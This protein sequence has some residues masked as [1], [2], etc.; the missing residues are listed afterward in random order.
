[1]PPPSTTKPPPSY[2]EAERHLAR[3]DRR[4]RKLIRRI[5]KCTLTPHDDYFSVLVHTIVSQQISSKAAL[6]I[7][8]R[9]AVAARSKKFRPSRL[10]A[11]DDAGMRACGISTGKLKSLRDLCAKV[12]DGTLPLRQLAKFEDGELRERLTAVHGIGPWS[13]DMFLMFSLGRPDILPVGDLGL[14]A[15]VQEVYELKM[16]PTPKELIEMAEPWRPYRSIATWY[17]WRSRGPVPQ[18]K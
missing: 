18:S 2:R 7:L 3:R 17:F 10:D 14:R 8:G 15:G 9:L 11:L 4:L 6:S 12:R 1:M 16:L 13:A 5:G